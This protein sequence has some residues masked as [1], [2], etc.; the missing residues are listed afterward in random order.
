MVVLGKALA[1]WLHTV[2]IQRLSK[3]NLREYVK[4]PLAHTVF[5]EEV[6]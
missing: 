6:A 1:E 2:V 5:V 3:T 4:L